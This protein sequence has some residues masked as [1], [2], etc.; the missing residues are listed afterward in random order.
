MGDLA[1]GPQFVRTPDD[2][3]AGL[4]DYPFQPHYHNWNGLRMHYLDEG[5]GSPIVLLHGQPTFSYLYR[6]F[7]PP[8]TAAGFRCVA[9]DYIGFGKSDKVIDD[10]WYRISKHRHSVRELLFDVFDLRNITL[11]VHD[12]GGPIGL[13]LVVE[14]PDRFE[15]LF[16]F[17]TWL[18]HEGFDF[19]GMKR[20]R[21]FAVTF[22][23]RTGDIPTGRLGVAAYDAPFPD[24]TYKA[25]PRRFPFSHPY[26]EP[27]LGDAALQAK[28]Y[29]ALKSWAKPTHFIFGDSDFVFTRE[30]GQQWASLFSN[31]TFRYRPWSALPAGE[32]SRRD[33][34]P[35]AE[36][37]H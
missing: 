31:A 21:D 19:T 18:H 1:A 26:A 8:L 14:S 37:Y 12:W 9:P 23:A 13:P 17:N 27:D 35:N 28:T 10:D 22:P 25:G 6:K 29:E 11:V 16:I 2:R 34:R 3:F 7:I 20:Y 33:G 32:Q 36:V 15:R 24:P 5:S 4:P 30:W